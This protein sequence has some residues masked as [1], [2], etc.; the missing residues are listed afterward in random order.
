VQEVSRAPVVSD[1][2]AS[3]FRYFRLSIKLN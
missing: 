1:P 3:V 2:T